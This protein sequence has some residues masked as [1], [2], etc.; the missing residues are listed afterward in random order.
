MSIGEV[1]AAYAGVRERIGGLVR[2]ADPKT[3][4]PACPEWTVH[5]VVAHVT[6]VVDD[7]LA[8]R[9][10]GAGTDPWTEA[11][12]AARKDVSIDDLLTEWNERAPSFEE[13]LDT[14]GPTGRQAVFDVTTHEHDVRGALGQPGAHDSDGVRIGLGWLAP[15][16]VAA[17]PAAGLPSIVIRTTEG[18]E[19][20]TDDN[21]VTVLTGSAFDLFRSLSGRRSRKQLLALDWSGDAE[22]YL[23]AFEMGPFRIPG[24]DIPD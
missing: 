16:L 3:F 6:G 21:P 12:V 15:Q 18:E 19:W 11:Q 1:G 14:I 4:V 9:L 17:M 2:A 20:A 10:E 7:A 24:E 22:Q 23:P 13:L 5:D 8:G